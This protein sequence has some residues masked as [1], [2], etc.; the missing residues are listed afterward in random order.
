MFKRR[1]ILCTTQIA[2]GKDTGALWKGFFILFSSDPA[3]ETKCYWPSLTP[4]PGD[5]SQCC[6]RHKVDPI[7]I[8]RR[9][10]TECPAIATGVSSALAF[11][12][13]SFSFFRV[14]AGITCGRVGSWI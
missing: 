13:G 10:R 7:E 4:I 14:S 6:P 8:S 5:S 1:R 2:P 11:P 12:L 9:A 3:A